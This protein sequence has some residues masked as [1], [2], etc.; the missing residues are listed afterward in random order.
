M[1]E[2][3]LLL[4]KGEYSLVNQFCIDLDEVLKDPLVPAVTGFSELTIA[5]DGLFLTA[6]ITPMWPR[7]SIYFGLMLF[8]AGL[9]GIFFLSWSLW[10]LLTGML[11]FGLFLDYARGV[12]RAR[13]L[14]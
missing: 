7:M 6:D 2:F 10:V 14:L 3:T 12:I 13:L 8:I 1:S 9:I 4:E 5:D 11:T